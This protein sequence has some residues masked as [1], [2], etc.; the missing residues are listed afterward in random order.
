MIATA[1]RKLRLAW[2]P[3][4]VEEWYEESADADYIS[5][6]LLFIEGRGLMRLITAREY[7]PSPFTSETLYFKNLLIPFPPAWMK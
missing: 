4:S 5:D 6:T 7:N 2:S 1:V 3:Q